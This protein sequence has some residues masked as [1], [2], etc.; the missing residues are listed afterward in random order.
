MAALTLNLLGAVGGPHHLL[1]HSL[2]HPTLDVVV[3]RAGPKGQ[4]RSQAAAREP[5]AQPGDGAARRHGCS[6]RGIGEQLMQG[7]RLSSSSGAANGST[8]RPRENGAPEMQ[9]LGEH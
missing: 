3:Q 4:Q 9:G 2:Y 8:K 1:L 5:G 7:W 6:G